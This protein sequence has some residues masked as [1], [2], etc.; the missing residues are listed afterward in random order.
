MSSLIPYRYNRHQM[1]RFE[2]PVFDDFFRSFFGNEQPS[3]GFRVDV[4]DQGDH[5]LLEADLPGMPREQ[6]HVDVEDGVL[7]ISAEQKNEVNEEKN[8]YVY[9]ERRYGRMQRSFALDQIQEDAITAE[10]KDGVLSL[11]LPKKS[12]PEQGK[13]RIEL[14]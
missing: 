12:A 11:K 1:N 3:A 6:V 8:N 5:Y 7:T 13:R 2:N 14:G 9:N 4:R 10:Y